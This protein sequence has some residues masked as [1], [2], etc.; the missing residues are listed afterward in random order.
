[1]TTLPLASFVAMR[2]P[3]TRRMRA[4]AV[5]C[6][7]DDAA[8]RTRETRWSLCRLLQG[9]RQQT[10]GDALAGVSSMIQLPLRGTPLMP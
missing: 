7:C 8:L 9:Q 6:V 4:L 10:H 5:P 3:D 1:M 2:N